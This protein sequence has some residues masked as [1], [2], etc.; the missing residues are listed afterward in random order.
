MSENNE[1]RD[2]LYLFACYLEWR[3]T[4]DLAAYQE[5]LAV[6]DGRDCDIRSFAEGMLRR[7]PAR[8]ADDTDIEAW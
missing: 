7:S 2:A 8:P 6:L 5:L 3:T 1:H 4:Q